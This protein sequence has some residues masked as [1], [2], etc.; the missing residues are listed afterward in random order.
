VIDS[1]R[2]LLDPGDC[3]SIPLEDG[4]FAFGQYLLSHPKV[5]TL[6]RVFDL[7][8]STRDV[9]VDDLKRSKLLFAPIFVGL[10]P[11]VRS[12]RWKK[13]GAFPIEDDFE[14]PRFRASLLLRDTENT[15]WKIWDGRSYTQLGR[16]TPEFKHLELKCVY[17]YGDVERRIL[18]GRDWI[19]DMR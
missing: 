2:I 7:R 8:S 1:I 19:A 5:G 9:A 6:I 18:T 4:T 10:N 15:D 17:A 14:F 11:P 3:F 12:G 16:L 13:V